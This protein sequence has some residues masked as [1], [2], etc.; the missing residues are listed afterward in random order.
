VNVVLWARSN[1]SL[2]YGDAAGGQHGVLLVTRRTC[3]V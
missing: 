3:W 2:C 1:V